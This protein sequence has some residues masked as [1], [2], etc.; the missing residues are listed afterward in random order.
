[1][2]IMHSINIYSYYQQMVSI[3]SGLGLYIP[4]D[5]SFHQGMT[6]LESHGL[7]YI[8]PLVA[9]I[10]VPVAVRFRYHTKYCNYTWHIF[11]QETI[12]IGQ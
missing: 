2:F 7:R 9:L 1:M 10:V 3:G 4:Y 6:S 11:F 5:F 12:E 8:A